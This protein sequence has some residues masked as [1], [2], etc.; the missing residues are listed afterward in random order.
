MSVAQVR[1]ESERINKSNSDSVES[2][3]YNLYKSPPVFFNRGGD[4]RRLN[5]YEPADLEI[6]IRAIRKKFDELLDS[7]NTV[8]KDEAEAIY[9]EMI[10][11]LRRR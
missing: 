4:R 1:E 7:L 3:V 5:V 9:P 8:R 10:A 11:L 6:F 2:A